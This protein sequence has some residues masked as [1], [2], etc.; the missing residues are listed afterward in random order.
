[1]AFDFAENNRGSGFIQLKKT[2]RVGK[3]VCISVFGGLSFP[4]AI[5]SE[6]FCV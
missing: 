3:P 4:A 6:C 2:E 1:M 5:D